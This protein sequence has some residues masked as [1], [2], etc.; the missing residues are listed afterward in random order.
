[1]SLSPA[2]LQVHVKTSILYDNTAFD[3]TE[4]DKLLT[5]L[6]MSKADDGVMS[7]IGRNFFALCFHESKLI[8][9]LHLDD[10][11]VEFWATQLSKGHEVYI[12]NELPSSVAANKVASNA[13]ASSKQKE[14]KL[15]HDN[16]QNNDQ[17]VQKN[18]ISSS[19]D[20]NMNQIIQAQNDKN[21]KN[22]RKRSRNFDWKS[23][24]LSF[25]EQHRVHDNMYQN[26]QMTSRAY[27]QVP[28]PNEDV[29]AVYALLHERDKKRQDL[30]VKAS[31]VYKKKSSNSSSSSSS[32]SNATSSS[33]SL[34]TT[35]ESAGDFEF[36]FYSD[37]PQQPSTPSSIPEL[38]CAAPNCKPHLSL[39]DLLMLQN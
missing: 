15:D 27:Q 37:T 23:P 21:N 39:D 34:A 11:D 8:K 30:E 26:N 24:F 20:E 14:Q 1:M 4:L 38:P 10:E 29:A 33:L 32:R 35:P 7:S 19:D 28:V 25:S 13:K 9:S 31:M 16:K 2:A 22:K 36:D 3:P 17:K 5:A 18:E 12:E 6:P